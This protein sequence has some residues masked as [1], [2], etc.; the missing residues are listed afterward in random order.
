MKN[1]I[2]WLVT[3]QNITGVLTMA[4]LMLIVRDDVGFFSLRTTKEKLFFALTVLMLLTNFTG[5]TAYYSG[6]QYG[7]LILIS[8]FMAVPLYYLFYG[9]W[10]S[11]YP[12]VG[13]AALFLI[14]HTTNGYM[15]FITQ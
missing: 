8:Q 13:T 11:N 3:I 7:W 15:N 1:E 10:K 2:E 6:Y 9:V 14:F 12:M 5:W 4:M